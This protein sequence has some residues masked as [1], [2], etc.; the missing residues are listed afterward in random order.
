[1]LLI[2]L[3]LIFTNCSRKT[4]PIQKATGAIEINTPFNTKEFRSDSDNFRAV[5]SGSSPDLSTSKKIAKQNARAALAADIN[6]LVKRVTDQYTNQRTVSNA[7][8]FENKFEELSRETV[9]L[10]ISNVR[11]IGEENFKES[12]GSY[13]CWIA[14]EVNK[15][16]V[17]EQINSKIS[18]D[19]K[20]KLDYDKQ[21]FE[22]IF[23]EEMDKLQND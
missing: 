4:T 20:L 6:S 23:N 1:M 7:Q 5:Q 18:N 10:A 8:E 16:E 14:I 11:E 19:D 2:C 17:F 13:T 3:T 22:K 9:M 15:K 21:K 12:N